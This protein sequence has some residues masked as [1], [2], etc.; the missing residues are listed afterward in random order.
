MKYILTESQ[1]VK[2]A[3]KRRLRGIRKIIGETLAEFDPCE[4]DEDNDGPGFVEYFGDVIFE[5]MDKIIED[6]NVHMPFDA[7]QED[8][9]RE[10]L[11]DIIFE[12]YYDE[13]KGDYD[14]HIR[15]LC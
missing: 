11:S 4:Y 13:V 9:I 12:I 6:I 2:L 1:F 5:A 3:V 10:S 15:D 7:E 8:E 14:D